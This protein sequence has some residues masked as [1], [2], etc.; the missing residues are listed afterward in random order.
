MEQKNSS[1]KK[2]RRLSKTPNKEE[3]EEYKKIMQS[4]SRYGM[5]V[6]DYYYLDH[7]DI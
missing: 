3:L 2:P 6:Y 4:E 7:N 1:V 5:S